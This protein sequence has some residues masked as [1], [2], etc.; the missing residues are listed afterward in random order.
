LIILGVLGG[1]YIAL[2]GALAT[3]A[4]TD[5]GHRPAHYRAEACAATG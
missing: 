4:L 2:G 3:L 5:A 1:I